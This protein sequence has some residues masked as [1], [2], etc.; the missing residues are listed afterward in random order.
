LRSGIIA[1]RHLPAAADLC[2]CPFVASD[3]MGGTVPSGD[4]SG[5]VVV[6]LGYGM[7]GTVPSRDESGRAVIV[8]RSGRGAAG[9][10]MSVFLS[11]AGSG[12]RIAIGHRWVSD[13]RN[14]RRRR[15]R[16]LTDAGQGGRQLL[17][18]AVVGARRQA[19]GLSPPP[20]GQD[21]GPAASVRY[22]LNQPRRGVVSVM[23]TNGHDDRADA[24][25][26]LR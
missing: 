8:L 4:E 3:G 15:A 12:R 5:R 1:V 18:A 22:R 7:G 19:P 14:T 21:P 6:V 9:S 2:V 17:A 16:I 25:E 20:P 24:D 10:D 26:L 11:Q 23:G 13:S